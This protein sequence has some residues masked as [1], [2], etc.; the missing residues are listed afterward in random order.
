MMKKIYVLVSL[1]I[2]T[3]G[4]QKDEIVS[5][6]EEEAVQIKKQTLQEVRFNNL[7]EPIAEYFEGN[8]LEQKNNKTTSIFGEVRTDM[9]VKKLID[10][11]GKISYTFVLRSRTTSDKSSSSFYFDNLVIYEHDRYPDELYIIRYTPTEEWYKSSRDFKNYSGEITFYTLKGKKINSVTLHNGK[12]LKASK[13]SFRK[14][15]LVCSLHF[16][17]AVTIC[18][19]GGSMEG[20]EN[21]YD[22]TCATTYYYSLTCNSPG[23]GGSDGGYNDPNDEPGPELDEIPTGGGGWTPP[24]LPE[25]EEVK[26]VNNL[27]DPCAKDIFQNLRTGPLVD[28]PLKPEVQIPEEEIYNLST[29]ILDLFNNHRTVDYSVGNDNSGNRTYASYGTVYTFLDNRYLSTATSLSIARTLIDEGLHAYLLLE[30]SN[31]QSSLFRSL[32]EY[33]KANGYTDLNDIHHNFMGSYIDA[34]AYSL[35]KWDSTYG[36]GGIRN[37]F[38]EIDAA[39]YRAMAFGG[40][41]KFDKYGNRIDYDSFKALV[42]QQADRD[43]IVKIIKNEQDGNSDSRGKDC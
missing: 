12:R 41:Y 3:L 40:F 27:T 23:G 10:T 9:P 26:V 43:E 25:P 37:S 20:D 33:A 31:P 2:F 29:E 16:V 5:Q 15:S 18:T 14:E 42:P 28:H 24:T 21:N 39:Y 22:F 38:G 30:N 35:Y 6:P 19:N 17:K 34:M 8:F 36:T 7:P 4:C 32:E 13:Q 1:L 11:T